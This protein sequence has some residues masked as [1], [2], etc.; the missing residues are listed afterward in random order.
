[1]QKMNPNKHAFQS[2]KSRRESKALRRAKARRHFELLQEK[3]LLDDH[4]AEF[5][6]PPNG[7][8]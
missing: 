5:W 2:T 1:M 6:D 8:S 7:K 3:R 4:L